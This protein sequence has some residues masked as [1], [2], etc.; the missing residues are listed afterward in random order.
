MINPDWRTV[1]MLEQ[2][3]DPALT[4]ARLRPRDTDFRRFESESHKLVHQLVAE[5]SIEQC[6]V[7]SAAAGALLWQAIVE[8]LGG[9]RTAQEVCAVLRGA[10]LPTL[11]LPL[12]NHTWIE[13]LRPL[14]LGAPGDP[15]AH[16]LMPCRA[17]KLARLMLAHAKTYDTAALWSA[18]EQAYARSR[19]YHAHDALACA[20]V[21]QRLYAEPLLRRYLSHTARQRG[22]RSRRKTWAI[23]R[24]AERQGYL[25]SIP[26]SAE[27][28]QME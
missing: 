28:D 3:P 16:G 15:V 21:D 2:V 26:Q 1:I 5:L 7:L 13:Y 17:T 20:L 25:A 27:S 9:E 23:A 14:A 8:R 22:W 10:Y 11:A 4:L 19:P 6:L 12:L 18:A 24:W